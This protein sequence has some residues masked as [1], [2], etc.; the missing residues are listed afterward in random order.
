MPIRS[1]LTTLLAALLVSIVGCTAVDADRWRLF[2]DEGIRLFAQADYPHALECF[3][4]A[5]TLHS[6]DPIL[7]FN[8][9]RCYDRLGNPIK[10]EQYYSNCLQLDPKHTD[11]RLALIEAKF[12][13]GQ[14]DQAKQMIQD[15]LNQDP[16]AADPIV[17]DAW[18][19]RREK[20]LPA[21]QARLEE[22]LAM[23]MNNLHALTEM[24]IIQE[25]EGLHDRAYVLYERILERDPKQDA[26]RARLDELKA[27]GVKRPTPN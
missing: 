9:A 3:D 1:S 24:A 8:M 14:A 25:E 15:W 22:A 26:I 7:V 16:H 19:L 23:D 2:N 20:N 21:A 13:A 11:A 5:L 12:R 10:A 6:Q 4:Y 27:K 17:A 18:R